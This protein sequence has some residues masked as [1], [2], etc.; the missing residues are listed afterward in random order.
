VSTD[1]TDILFW[2]NRVLNLVHES[3]PKSKIVLLKS[4]QD[5]QDAIQRIMGAEQK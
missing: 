5:L 1:R 2:F 4:P 3:A